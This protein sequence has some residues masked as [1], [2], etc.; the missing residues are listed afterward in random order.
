MGFVFR[1]EALDFR[2]R[3]FNHSSESKR[4]FGQK[5][6]SLVIYSFFC[7]LGNSVVMAVFFKPYIV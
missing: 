3:R 4:R 6:S 2:V 1:I 5:L 7:L